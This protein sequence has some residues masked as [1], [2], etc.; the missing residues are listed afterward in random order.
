MREKKL[1]YFTALYNA[2]KVVN[3]SLDVSH[4]L[5]EIVHCVTGTMKVKACSLRLLDAKGLRLILGAVY[6]LSEQYLHK[7]R[8]WLR[9]RGRQ[10][11]SQG[12]DHLRAG[13]ATDRSFQYGQWRRPRRSSPSWSCR[14]RSP[15]A[16]SA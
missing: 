8:S 7:A 12:R 11:V 2:A 1:D 10:E 4:I 16:L 5:N 9:E 6:G 3:G 13:R 15:I 14:S